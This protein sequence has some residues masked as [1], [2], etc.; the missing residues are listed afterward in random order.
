MKRSDAAMYAAK[1]SGKNRF[2]FH[3]DLKAGDR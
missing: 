3:C 1:Q 2:V